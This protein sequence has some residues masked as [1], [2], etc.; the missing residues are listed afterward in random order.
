V[1]RLKLNAM[2]QFKTNIKCAACIEKVTPALNE[3]VGAGQWQVDVAT[4]AKTLTIQT[5][6][7]E[8]VINEALKQKGYKVEAV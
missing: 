5:D 8:N 6:T 2:K 3:V 4:P 1:E 7:P